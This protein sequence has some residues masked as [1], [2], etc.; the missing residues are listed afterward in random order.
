LVP[1]HVAWS[2][3]AVGRVV[4]GGVVYVTVLLFADRL[5]ARSTAWTTQAVHQLGPESRAHERRSPRRDRARTEIR[6]HARY[7]FHRCE[8][9]PRTRGPLLTF[10]GSLMESW[11]QLVALPEQCPGSV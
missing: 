4:L 11:K 8:R 6:R 7:S 3:G 10:S 5:A 9:L 2:V 1:T